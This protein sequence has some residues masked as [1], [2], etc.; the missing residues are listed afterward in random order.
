MDGEKMKIKEVLFWII[1]F[2]AL[3][4]AIS[5]NINCKMAGNVYGLDG[6]KTG[7]WDGEAVPDVVQIIGEASSFLGLGLSDEVVI[8]LATL[9]VGGGVGTGVVAKKKLGKG[10]KKKK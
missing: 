10:K 9:L 7:T 4:L 8:M 3:A 5:I 6:E 2:A 1:M